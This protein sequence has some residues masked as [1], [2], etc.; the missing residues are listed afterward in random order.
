MNNLLIYGAYGYTGR[1]IVD[2]CLKVGIKPIIAGRSA[3]KAMKFANKHALE[4]DVFEVSEREKLENWLKRGDVVIHCGGPF[5]HTAKDMVEACIATDTHYLDITGEYQ[6]FD[7]IKEY[8][9][10][11][12]DKNLMLMPGAGFDVVPSDCLAMHLHTKLPSATDLTLAFV[13]KG[14]KLSRGTAKTMIENLGDPQIRRRNGAYEGLPMGKSIREIDYGDFTQLSMGISWGDVST[15]Y[16]STSIPN[17]EV[18]SGTD[19]Q[20][21][22]KVKKTLRMS[23]MLKSRMIKNFLIRQMDKRPDGPKEEKRD[24]SCMYLWGEASN[25]KAKVEARLKTPNGYSLTAMSSVLIAQKVF[26]GD[27]KPGFQT[28]SSAYGEGL[29]LE[30]D[31]CFYL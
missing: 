3:E 20:Q 19:E 4:Y 2:E 8:N 28:P 17:I 24:A 29:I 11:A 6:V 13:S 27:F 25:G 16:H 9:Q 23:F 15:A 12:I 1:I 21:I 18:F 31:G 26:A 30:I 7:L 5:I 14:G 10:Q 22:S